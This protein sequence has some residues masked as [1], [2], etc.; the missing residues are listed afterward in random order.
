VGVPYNGALVATGGVPG[1]TF[2]ISSG[3]LPPVLSL[4]ASTGAITGTPTIGGPFN[5]TAKVVDSRGTL[6]GTTTTSCLIGVADVSRPPTGV[7][8]NAAASVVF[9]AQGPLPENAFVIR[10]AANLNLG[11]SLINISNSG[12]NGA[13][14]LGPGFGASAG[15]LCVS[16]YT[17]SPDEQLVSCCS[18][19]VT[20]N[21]LQSL[22]VNSDLLN[23]TLTGVVPTSAVVKLVGSIPGTGALAGGVLAWGTTVHPPATLTETPFIPA[24]LGAPELSSITGRCASILGNGSGFGICQSCRAGAL[25][26]TKLQ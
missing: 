10:Y 14:L 20:P 15:N 5:F 19:L 18:C 26:A 12:L 13:P 21:A 3:N 1:Y 2:S 8:A 24:T 4:N 23:S 6:A 22:S 25:G 11:D 7:C 16:V 17:F 9:P